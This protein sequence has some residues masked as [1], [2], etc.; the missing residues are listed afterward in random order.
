MSP[1]RRVWRKVPRRRAR[2]SRGWW[3]LTR[4]RT[5]R[6]RKKAG[7]RRPALT[8]SATSSSLSRVGGRGI[9]KSRVTRP[10]PDETHYREILPFDPESGLLIPVMEGRLTVVEDAG[11]GVD[12]QPVRLYH[13]EF[14]H[15]AHNFSVPHDGTCTPRAKPQPPDF[16]RHG[17]EDGGGSDFTEAVT[18]MFENVEITS[19]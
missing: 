18:V 15:Y 19:E 8:T 2:S 1:R 9:P 11:E 17:D 4:W 5:R 12:N 10:F 16:N 13:A 3:T 7:R 6:W 14:Y